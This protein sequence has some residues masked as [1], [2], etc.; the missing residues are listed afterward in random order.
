[1]DLHGFCTVLSLKSAPIL[2]RLVCWGA[3]LIAMR[4]GSVPVVRSTGGLRDTVFDAD[5][6]KARAAWE[7]EGSSDWERDGLDVTNGFAF[8]VRATAC[9]HEDILSQ[10]PHPAS[11]HLLFCYKGH[12]CCRMPFLLS[13]AVVMFQEKYDLHPARGLGCQHSHPSLRP[14]SNDH[15]FCAKAHY[16]S[17]QKS[18]AWPCIPAHALNDGASS[19]PSLGL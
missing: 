18:M 17:L 8:E 1:M 3:Q 5:L 19:M 13:N 14:V 4:Y 10:H 9:Q 7:L 16:L 2:T 12:F 15:A 6:D 11:S